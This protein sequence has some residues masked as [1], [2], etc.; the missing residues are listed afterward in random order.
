MASFTFLSVSL[1][2]FKN[3]ISSCIFFFFLDLFLAWHFLLPFDWGVSNINL[4]KFTSI[5]SSI[6]FYVPFSFSTL[7]S[8]WYFMYMYWILFVIIPQ[9]W[10]ILICFSQSLFCLLFRFWSFYCHIFKLR[11]SLVSHS[12]I[13]SLLNEPLKGIHQ[14]CDSI[15]HL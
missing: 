14:F 2:K 7:F 9:F 6:F 10:V 13:S 12:A 4:H 5:I 3:D 8:F 15:L 1:M 11:D